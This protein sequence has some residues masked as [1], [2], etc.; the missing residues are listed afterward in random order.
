MD[1]GNNHKS[2]LNRWTP[3]NPNTDVPRIYNRAQN[4]INT[5]GNASSR[6]LEDGDFLRV[7]NITLGYNLSPDV[8]SSIGL[9]AV[10]SFRIYAQV[11]NAF[12]FTKYTG[13]DPEA[14]Y[15]TSTDTNSATNALFGIEW[16]TNPPVRTFTVGV[17]I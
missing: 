10:R 12:V 8:L 4:F 16:N 13:S 17:N 14:N 3:L 9:G 7:Q 11:Q 6:F 2:I 15:I 5:N 1:F